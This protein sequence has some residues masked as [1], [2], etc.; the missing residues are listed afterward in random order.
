[1]GSLTT[2]E[3]PIDRD[4]DHLCDALDRDAIDVLREVLHAPTAEQR[5]VTVA[6]A[7]RVGG[8]RLRSDVEVEVDPIVR[9]SRYDA[10]L[11]V[12]WYAAR[13][14][15]AIPTGRATLHLTALSRAPGARSTLSVTTEFEP[16]LGPI[17]DLEFAIE[18]KSRLLRAVEARLRAFVAA[19][20]ARIP[21]GN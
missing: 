10:Q 18:G 6:A 3:V 4:F 21:A 5:H 11:S 8:V 17:G 9:H 7:R 16:A 2:I 1:M 14:R 20:Q 12:R 13:H 19:L 15:V